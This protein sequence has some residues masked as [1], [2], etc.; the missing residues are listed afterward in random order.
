MSKKLVSLLAG[1]NLTLDQGARPQEGSITLV[2]PLG[3]D[4]TT[5]AIEEGL[6]PRRCVAVDMLLQTDKRITLMGSPKTDRQ[7]IDTAWSALAGTGRAVTVINDSTG[8]IAQRIVANIIN[9]ACEIAQ[10]GIAK[11]VAID[12]GARLG[13][14]YPAGPLAMGDEIGA[15]VVLEILQNLQAISG[16]QR[17]RPGPWLRRRAVLNLSL[18]HEE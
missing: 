1:A 16:D 10:M 3:K 17:Y 15:G 2:T 13:L 9:T 4:A 14:G 11:P 18:L 6:D 7:V 8:F 5:A 12:T